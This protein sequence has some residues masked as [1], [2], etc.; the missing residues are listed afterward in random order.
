MRE[1]GE[2]VPEDFYEEKWT[3]YRFHKN[4][5]VYSQ[6]TEKG[7][8]EVDNIIFEI[9]DTEDGSNGG[10]KAGT[11]QITVKETTLGL[12]SRKKMPD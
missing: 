5:Q 11:F 8:L 10:L 7:V 1:A 4:H 9:D 6:T 3:S 2:E 12:P